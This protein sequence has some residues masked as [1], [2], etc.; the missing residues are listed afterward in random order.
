VGHRVD[1]G[2]RWGWKHTGD[3]NDIG[4]NVGRHVTTLGLNDGQ[5]SERTTAELVVHLGRALKETRVEVENVTGVGLTPRRTP[6][7]QRHLT[8]GHGLLCQVVVDNERVLAVVAEPIMSILVS[9]RNL[10]R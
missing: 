3:G 7:Q 9:I 8:V 2:G 4:G 5:S 1:G 6:E 10:I